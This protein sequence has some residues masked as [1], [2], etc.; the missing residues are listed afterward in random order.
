M[1][2]I[3][4]CYGCGSL[5]L[6]W[7]E[8]LETEK[9]GIIHKACLQNALSKYVSDS[10]LRSWYEAKLKRDTIRAKEILGLK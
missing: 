10:F 2:H 8:T 7:S 4:R 6:P 3:K 1:K 9:V 5:I